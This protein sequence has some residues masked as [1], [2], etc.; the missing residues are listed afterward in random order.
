MPERLPERLMERNVK[1]LSSA[2]EL[3]PSLCRRALY[4]KSRCRHCV[5]ACTIDALQMDGEARRADSHCDGCGACVSACP[6]GALDLRPRNVRTIEAEIDRRL[7]DHPGEGVF[8]ACPRAEE[9]PKGA[10]EVPCAARLDEV[11]LAYGPLRG[12]A[13]TTVLTGDCA[14]CSR[15]DR[16]RAVFRKSLLAAR[17][18]METCGLDPRCVWA[19]KADTLPLQEGQ[20]ERSGGSR[21]EFF[22]RL[23][24]PEAAFIPPDPL[25]RNGTV[26]GRR[27]R[28]AAAIRISGREYAEGGGAGIRGG[29]LS[30]SGKCLGCPVCAH[31]CAQGA[32]TRE[33]TPEGQVVVRF[34]PALCDACG[35]CAEACMPRAIALRGPGD[36]G[37][38]APTVPVTLIAL[39]RRECATCR[40]P[41]YSASSDT[42]P[43]CAR[44]SGNGGEQGKN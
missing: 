35:A 25:A 16:F 3:R 18:I 40:E 38:P 17:S 24:R 28:L 41:Y 9:R 30:I 37:D 19:R 26:P 7:A 5:Q 6:T 21:R 14:R 8:L 42:C 11:T 20:G 12:V 27:A 31:V 32:I 36:P 23:V 33:E 34:D 2:L 43:R 10:L 39:T 22:R 4:A 44:F 13:H 1:V 29:A 15:G